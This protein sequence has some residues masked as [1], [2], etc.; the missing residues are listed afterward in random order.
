MNTIGFIGGGRITRIFLQAYANKG[1]TLNNIVVFDPN[2]EVLDKLKGQF[3]GIQTH[4][5]T[6][7]ETARAE[8]I[9]LA[10]HPPAMMDVLNSLKDI[11]EPAAIILSFAPKFTIAKIRSVLT[12]NK[13]IARINPSASSY[14]NKGINPVVYDPEMDESIRTRIRELMD[15]LGNLP[16]V[17][18]SKIEAYAMISAMGPTY[19]WFQIRKLQ[20]LAVDFGMD[21]TE[22]KQVISAMISG[23]IDTLFN[24][25][26]PYSEVT[27]L[28][29]LKPLGP[30]ESAILAHYDENLVPLFNKIKP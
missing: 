27:D 4:S 16:E 2:R 20:E 21:S 15:P 25:G 18:E 9:V 22:A 30:A 5:D 3:P 12:N 7:L 8:F 13:Q 17:V 23:T 29:P 19:Y 1:L 24:S 11:V 6:L 10:V 28:V 14:I 26:L